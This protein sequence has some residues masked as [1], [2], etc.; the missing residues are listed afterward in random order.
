MTHFNPSDSG[1]AR[2]RPEDRWGAE[3]SHTHQYNISVTFFLSLV[4]FSIEAV[5]KNAP[6]AGDEHHN[7]SLA[8]N[9]AQCF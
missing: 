5:Q 7:Y 4:S 2:N 3:S 9:L 6:Y 1:G 8:L